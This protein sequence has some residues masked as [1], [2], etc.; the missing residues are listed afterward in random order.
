MCEAGGDAG[1]ASR[2]P[3][4]HRE[5]TRRM[6]DECTAQ[7]AEKRIGELEKELADCRREVARLKNREGPPDVALFN[8]SHTAM[9]LVDPSDGRIVDANP[10]ACTFYGYD[11]RTLT[12]MSSAD[13]NTL[14]PEALSAAM[15]SARTGRNAMFTFQ[16][17]LADG[18][19]R[20]VEVHSGPVTVGG[21]TLLFSIIHDITKR[22][23]ALE[24]LR[25]S[26]QL[27]SAVVQQASD[28]IY[29]LDPVTRRVMEANR[30]LCRMLGYT[31]EEFSRL[32]VYDFVHHL[33]EDIDGIL[34]RVAHEG[35]LMVGERRYR[36]KDGG[37]IDVEVSVNSVSFSGKNLLCVVVRDITD[38]K[39]AERTLKK[40][41]QLFDWFM[42]HLPAVA[43]MKDLNGRYIFY[44]QASADYFGQPV[45]ERLGKT[46]DELWPPE[47]AAV[48][49]KNDRRVMSSGR[50]LN[51]L[52]VGS[53][54][55]R[56]RYMLVTKFP[57]FRDGKP[58]ILAG[59][60]VDIT[61]RIEA[62]RESQHL[63]VQ[64]LQAQ[65]M[66]AIGTL[67]G[68]IA[69][70]F[71]N[72]LMGILGRTSIM[73]MDCSPSDP[74]YE[75]LKGIEAHVKSAADL[76][77]QL[78]GF[79]RGG[80]Y[81]VQPLDIN[82]LLREQNTMF[83]RT[84]KE[85]SFHED[86]QEDLWTV[87]ADAGQLKQVMLNL[88]V[89]ACQAMPGG[90]RLFIRT[91]NVNLDR[92]FTE[93]SEVPPGAYVQ[94]SVT[95]TGVGMDEATRERIFEPF[96][97]TREMGHG[98]GLGLASAYGIIKNHAGIIQ[99]KSRK[100]EGTTFDI[101]LPA[102]NKTPRPR[103]EHEET[104]LEGSETVLLVDDE[105]MV[106]EVGAKMMSRLGYR[107]LTATSGAE[108][109]DIFTRKHAQIDVVILDM[110]MPE[111]NGEQTLRRLQEIDPRVRVIFSSGY[112]RNHQAVQDTC[113][114]DFPFIQKPFNIA[115]L[116]RRLREVLDS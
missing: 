107:V 66:E 29:L 71:N 28:G 16:H 9:L 13:I 105:P 36:R 33:R 62:E 72:L 74:R 8:N 116:S 63:K 25:E 95:D 15:E 26:R 61:D 55:G 113:C 17:R 89:N 69:H 92:A 90:G 76:T 81:N 82:A 85:V 44:N 99:V 91:R 100:G 108:A 21:R 109:L 2:D 73:L 50:S 37:L 77:R 94:V 20:D 1:T 54:N 22:R 5:K 43:F 18:S 78:L 103:S 65:K 97:T 67:A 30:S 111:M 88:Y 93:H 12:A 34:R 4:R 48:I 53:V 27:Y 112:S 59:F 35:D 101:Y 19:L 58:F 3:K 46:D 114:R 41:R 80:K 52:E 7:D 40:S 42:K 102:S 23:R 70:D 96:F 32:R 104:M 51:I 83:A 115:G 11:H 87:E 38:R 31:A 57:I 98:T 79:A 14:S 86:F 64:L 84:R 24:A 6:D 47:V 56:E 60:S 68:G 106:T 10:A 39:Q 49:R 110:I 75:H 45:E